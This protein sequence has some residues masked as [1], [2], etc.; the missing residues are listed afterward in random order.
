[1]TCSTHHH[2]VRVWLLIIQYHL[3]NVCLRLFISG[4]IFIIKSID[5]AR[6]RQHSIFN[7]KDCWA[8]LFFSRIYLSLQSNCASK[9]YD[10]LLLDTRIAM[11]MLHVVDRSCLAF[12]CMSFFEPC[13]LISFWVK[14]ANFNALSCRLLKS[15]VNHATLSENH[16]RVEH[17]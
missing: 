15:N 12:N 14:C 9:K 3:I 11:V 13:H 2:R 6:I 17:T 10:T 8:P 16:A 5:I 7:M 1:M 4:I